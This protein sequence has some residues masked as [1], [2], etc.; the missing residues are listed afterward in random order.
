MIIRILQC[1]YDIK[2]VNDLKSDLNL[3]MAKWINNINI[4]GG[5]LQ[6]IQIYSF[7]TIS[8]NPK[9]FQ[10]DIIFHKNADRCR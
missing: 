1:W 8:N 2:L 10:N 5:T 4:R 3:T 7:V 6:N 9:E